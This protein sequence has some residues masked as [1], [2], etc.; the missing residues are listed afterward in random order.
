MNLFLASDPRPVHF[1][2]IAGAGMSALAMLALKRGVAV[3]G[4]DTVPAGAPDLP[5]HGAR[6]TPGPDP[7]S[8]EGAR[9]VVTSAAIPADH[10]ELVKARELGL[11]VVPRKQA[12]ADLLAGK[13]TV[14]VAGTHGKT[15]TTAMTAE[16]LAAAG[17]D[18]TALVGG[19]VASWGGN[20]RVGGD[21]LYVVEADEYDQAFLA[22]V[23]T[24]AVVT[25]VEAE[26]LECYGG[27]VDRLM[28]AFVTFAGRS[29]TAIVSAD[30]AGATQV[31]ARLGTRVWRYGAAEGASLRLVRERHGVEGSE[32]RVIL[33]DART[34]T[35]RL[36]LVGSHNVRN[37]M[38][39]LGVAVAL[40]AAI[41]P[42]L[43]ALAEFGGVGRRFERLGE[44]GGVLVVDDYAHHPTE[45]AATLAAARQA[46]PGR[47]LLAVFQPHLYSRTAALAG[48]MGEALAAADRTYVTEV[49]GAREEPIPGVSGAMVAQAAQARGAPTAFEPA[50]DRLL[51][52]LAAEAA[53]GDVVLTLGAGDI[54]ALG[55]ALLDRL[56]AA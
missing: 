42:A 10:P 14:A 50:R 15:T 35:V 18:P 55:P 27:S 4:T 38:A 1:V 9:A 6:V 34:V 39:S 12:L 51:D 40:G 46:Y 21:E 31:A 20:A 33:P 28:D 8:V 5:R 47:R 24:I 22:L 13:R 43:D 37:A 53:A 44:Q 49:Y 48:P 7:R 45:I 25:T 16:A 32:A 30:D 11:A 56:A 41:E 17:L 2:G 29:E 54:T 26:H 36:R 19:R 3:T 23:P 52:R